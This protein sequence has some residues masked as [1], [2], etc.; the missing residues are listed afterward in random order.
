MLTLRILES[1]AYV[2][3]TNFCRYFL[4][5]YYLLVIK[6]FRMPLICFN[7]M[8]TRLV[9]ALFSTHWADASQLVTLAECLNLVSKIR[10]TNKLIFCL[11]FEIGRRRIKLLA[12]LKL[13]V[14]SPLL[15]L[16]QH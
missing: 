1:T 6:Y 11:Y 3:Q 10:A 5:G 15:H 8:D 14:V 4:M 7:L 16:F 9:I 13:L 12:S 2:T